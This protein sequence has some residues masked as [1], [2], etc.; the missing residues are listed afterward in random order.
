M[1]NIIE[2]YEGFF[3]D[4]LIGILKVDISNKKH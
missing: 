3:E 1:K 2:T 4:V